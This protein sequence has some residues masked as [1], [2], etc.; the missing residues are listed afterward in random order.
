MSVPSTACQKW[1][2]KGK[3]WS[4]G[5]PATDIHRRHQPRRKHGLLTS[6]VP[7]KSPI[8]TLASASAGYHRAYPHGRATSVATRS[9]R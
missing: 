9:V 4:K 5:D 3:G 2:A 6:W 8:F 7:E 1:S